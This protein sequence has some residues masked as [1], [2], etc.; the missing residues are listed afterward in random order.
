MELHHICIV[1]P[2][3]NNAPVLSKVIESVLPY[4]NHIV[5]VNDGSTDETATIL[6]SFQPQISVVSY[7]TN[8]GKGYALRQGFI[9]ARQHHFQAVLTLDSDG[10]HLAS[11]IPLLVKKYHSRP[12]TFIIGSRSFNEANIPSKN[13]FANKFSNFWFCVQTGISLSDTQTGFRLYPLLPMYSMLPHGH[14]YEAELELLVR[15]AWRNID[16]HEVPI[17]VYYP[18]IEERISHF[19][20][21]IDFL[22]ISLLNVGLCIAAIF[23]GYPARLIRKICA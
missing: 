17:H 10:Q 16:I 11:D 22:R 15:M 12:N 8:K 9:W 4:C 7:P 23:Y 14:R 19:R 3:Y 20:P 2:T 1:I 21:T 5:V 6:Q 18:P 13:T